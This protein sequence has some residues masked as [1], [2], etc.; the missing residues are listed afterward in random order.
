MS[1]VP[2]IVESMDSQDVRTLNVLSRANL[3]EYF[4][5]I[6]PNRLRSSYTVR[7]KSL[8]RTEKIGH[9]FSWRMAKWMCDNGAPADLFVTSPLNQ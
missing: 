9:M 8:P 5:D 3:L 2:A 7:P 4:F 6:Y 1:L